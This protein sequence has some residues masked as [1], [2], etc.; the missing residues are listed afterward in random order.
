VG[1]GVLGIR[2]GTTPAARAYWG[3]SRGRGFTLVMAHAN[4]PGRDDIIGGDIQL[5]GV[6]A[7]TH[8]TGTAIKSKDLESATFSIGPPGRPARITGSFTCG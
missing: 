7:K 8:I 2:I 4:R 5:P 1:F 6:T 3:T